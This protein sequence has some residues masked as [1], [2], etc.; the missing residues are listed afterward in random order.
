[1]DL[2]I[3]PLEIKILLESYPL[4]STLDPPPSS[5]LPSYPP[6]SSLLPPTLYG[7]AFIFEVNILEARGPAETH[8]PGDTEGR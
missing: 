4:P 7:Q 6:P 8:P 2:G 1:M 5:L 3:P